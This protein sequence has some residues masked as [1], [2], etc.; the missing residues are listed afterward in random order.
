M[1]ELYS[2][3]SNEYDALIKDIKQTP[4]IEKNGDNA[5]YKTN[6]GFHDVVCVHPGT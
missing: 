4:E 1:D 2:S 5:T 6:P 3:L